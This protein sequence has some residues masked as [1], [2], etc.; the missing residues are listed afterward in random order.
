M[1]RDNL[2]RLSRRSWCTTKRA[3]RLQCLV[4]LYVCAHNSIIDMKKG[5]RR[6]HPRQT[7]FALTTGAEM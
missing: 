6:Q 1:F 2:K 5:R 7:L 4:H 3:D